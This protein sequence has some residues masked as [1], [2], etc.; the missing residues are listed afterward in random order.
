MSIKVEDFRWEKGKNDLEYITLLKRNLDAMTY[1]FKECAKVAKEQYNKGRESAFKEIAYSDG[2]IKESECE[3]RIRA[4][5]RAKIL[6]PYDVESI[7]DLIENVRAKVLD[8]VL[9][10]VEWDGYT[11]DIKRRIERLKE[12]K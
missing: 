6:M 11:L 5:E 9:K 7:D 3:K 1:K 12:Q 4:D 2:L 8:E 10:V